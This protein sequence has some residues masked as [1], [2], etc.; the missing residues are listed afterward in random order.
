MMTTHEARICAELFAEE[1]RGIVPDDT[2][3]MVRSLLKEACGHFPGII[4]EIEPGNMDRLFKFFR[5]IIVRLVI[6]EFGMELARSLS[7]D[8]DLD[9]IV[10]MAEFRQEFV[11]G[12]E[13]ELPPEEEERFQ[14][15]IKK[16]KL[17]EE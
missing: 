7:R 15:L 12:G 8:L 13:P 2:I 16:L 11:N 14:G 9:V 17:H 4:R 10:V 1:K 5:A 3:N 6:E